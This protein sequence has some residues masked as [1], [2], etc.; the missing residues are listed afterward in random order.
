MG[1]CCTK[2]TNTFDHKNDHT[3]CKTT[4]IQEQNTTSTDNIRKYY[5]FDKVIGSGC[6]GSVK[7]AYRKEDPTKSYAIKQIP[8]V[9]Y[10]LTGKS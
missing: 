9:F 2:H 6:F 7:L 10:Y 3:L 8:L 1:S 4:Y 5:K